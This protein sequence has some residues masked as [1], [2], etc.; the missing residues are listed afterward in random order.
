MENIEEE[1]INTDI[2]IY[3]S[4][5]KNYNIISM[6]I[7]KYQGFEYELV[8]KKEEYEELLKNFTNLKYVNN[9]IIIDKELENVNLLKQQTQSRIYELK[10]NLE[11]T[12]YKIIKCYEAFMRQQTLPYNLEELI[13]QRDVWRAEIN[14]I[15]QELSSYE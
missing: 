11:K 2:K 7:Q 6:S 4:L 10:L 13:T 15:E 14:E 1:I 9:K 5:N 12:D 8:V 3:F